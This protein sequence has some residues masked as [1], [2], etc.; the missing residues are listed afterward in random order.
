MPL[1][2]TDP[3]PSNAHLLAPRWVM[4]G[5]VLSGLVLAVVFVLAVARAIGVDGGAR[6][7][8]DA[9]RSTSSLAPRAAGAA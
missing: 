1:P 7:S 6:S 5:L 3:T 4:A 2:P 8:G 9:V